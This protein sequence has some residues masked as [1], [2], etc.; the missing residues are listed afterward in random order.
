MY[1]NFVK[2]IQKSVLDI[3]KNNT[4]QT[5]SSYMFIELALPRQGE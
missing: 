5:T 4:R 3:F 1:K 2:D